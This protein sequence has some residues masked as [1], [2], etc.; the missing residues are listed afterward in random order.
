[1]HLPS[2]IPGSYH[3]A[4][5]VEAGRGRGRTTESNIQVME[6]M[7][8]EADEEDKEE[9]RESPP[10]TSIELYYG[11][12][13]SSSPLSC[14]DGVVDLPAEQDIMTDIDSA[15]LIFSDV[16][17]FPSLPDFTNLSD[18]E[19]TPILEDERGREPGESEV[20]AASEGGGSDD[21][22]VLFFEWLKSN[23]ETISPEDLKNIKLKRSTI[24]CAVRR[25]GGGKEGMKQLLK[26]ILSWVQNHHL[27]QKRCL[28]TDVGFGTNINYQQLPHLMIPVSPP[29]SV[30]FS[31]EFCN[32]VSP[33]EPM[34][35]G[36][37]YGTGGGVDA[38]SPIGSNE[39]LH[40][41]SEHIP[42]WPTTQRPSQF[43]LFPVSS[44]GFPTQSFFGPQYPIPTTPSF[45]RS[46]PNSDSYLRF[47]S[48][49]TKEARKKRMARQRRFI[50]FHNHRQNQ[51]LHHH[52]FHLQQQKQQQCSSSSSTH[53]DGMGGNA[54]P[55]KGLMP[56]PAAPNAMQQQVMQ[57]IQQQQGWNSEKNLRFLL[58]K[59]L[60][61]S[62]VG[63]LGRIVLPKKEAEIHLPEL[64]A[65]D[66][67]PITMEDIGTSRTWNMRYRFWPNNKSRMY[68]LENTGDFVRTND[69]QEGD[70]IVIYTDV[71]CGK[72]M[73][74]GVKVRNTS[75]DPKALKDTGE[76]LKRDDDSVEVC[77][78][79]NSS[80]IDDG[81]VQWSK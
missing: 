44:G 32:W 34:M 36:F 28:R 5:E 69:L 49:A 26:L 74:R 73:I 80:Q 2:W 57:Q 40:T 65:R 8:E 48:S 14:A 51:N 31:D 16:D 63:S 6:R 4:A 21:L 3:S 52:Q 25:L 1:M 66:G 58:Q 37:N 10:P 38:T 81:S 41:A 72:F 68:L 27:E 45:F 78:D 67:I 11:N 55:V 22:A 19:N 39:Q 42:I 54:W 56:N 30:P 77:C 79:E 62:D 71:K 13:V 23:K 35:P 50:S 53:D 47:G 70:F 76:N 7:R 12:H 33:I 61:Q 20:G 46:N 9:D 29:A 59:V 18:P 17:A 64:E 60:K 24:E 15:D 75:T 43:P